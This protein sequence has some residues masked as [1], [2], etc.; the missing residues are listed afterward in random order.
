MSGPAF[1]RRVLARTGVATAAVAVVP[2][3]VRSRAS[4]AQSRAAHPVPPDRALRAIL[5]YVF[6]AEG[7]Q[8]AL[9]ALDQIIS[10]DLTDPPISLTA[11]CRT[12]QTPNLSYSPAADPDVV[13]RSSTLTVTGILLGSVS[14]RD[15]LGGGQL[16]LVGA[17]GALRRQL[18]SAPHVTAPALEALLD[19]SSLV[20]LEA[21]ADGPADFDYHATEDR[22]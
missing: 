5:D 17:S 10:L 11:D 6:G 20:D 12:S 21:I 3:V 19:P 8:P 9:R 15:A 13:L 14:V 2:N 1:T 16:V 18:A 22:G 7:F 4:V